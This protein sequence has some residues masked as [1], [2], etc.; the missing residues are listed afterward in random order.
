MSE[1]SKNNII[2]NNYFHITFE[3]QNQMRNIDLNHLINLSSPSSLFHPIK[4]NY[5]IKSFLL[6]K[7]KNIENKII[8]SEEKEEKLLND[9]NIKLS[10]EKISIKNEIEYKPEEAKVITIEIPNEKPSIFKVE[11]SSINLKK[12]RKKTKK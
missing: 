5:G 10:N 7:R 3:N 2:I 12:I 4:N 6:K 9:K 8:I 1:E 11:N